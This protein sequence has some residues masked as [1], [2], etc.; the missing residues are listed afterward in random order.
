MKRK[1]CAR[2]RL[3]VDGNECPSCKGQSFSTN[4]LGRFFIFD[5][6]KSLIA[7][8]KGMGQEGEFAI[9]VR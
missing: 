5:V 8:K 4:W 6:K 2:C 7:Q 9:K 1:V 3:F